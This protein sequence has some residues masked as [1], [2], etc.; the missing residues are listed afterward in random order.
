VLK[1]QP[2]FS[3]IG[4]ISKVIFNLLII[5]HGSVNRSV[6]LSIKFSFPIRNM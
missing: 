6:N 4:A 1:I 2:Q 3:V 5:Y